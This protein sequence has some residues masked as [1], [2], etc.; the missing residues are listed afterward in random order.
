M[1]IHSLKSQALDSSARRY[2]ATT[3]EAPFL[4]L[5]LYLLSFMSTS[6]WGLTIGII[7]NLHSFKLQSC[8]SWV[9][10]FTV[11]CHLHVQ[12]RFWYPHHWLRNTHTSATTGQRVWWLLGFQSVSDNP[13]LTV[14]VNSDLRGRSC[15][16]VNSSAGHILL[17]S[18]SFMAY[19][20][21][22]LW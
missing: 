3:W 8:V 17:T 15:K 16:T 22:S 7:Q 11:I 5:P 6:R 13:K 10:Y 18:F 14:T 1:Q 20:S 2:R 4:P 19:E 21:N 9:Q 12:Y